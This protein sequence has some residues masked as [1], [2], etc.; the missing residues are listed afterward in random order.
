[1]TYEAGHEFP[2]IEV[3]SNGRLYIYDDNSSS[4]PLHTGWV[5]FS[6]EGSDTRTFNRLYTESWGCVISLPSLPF[7]ARFA[8]RNQK[9]QP[10]GSCLVLKDFMVQRD[11]FLDFETH[12]ILAEVRVDF[13]D[14]TYA[15]KAEYES[16]PREGSVAIVPFE[17][18]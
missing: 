15:V 11:V 5:A 3:L 9:M 1:M 4:R 16:D 17:L 13:H 7:K 6:F 10:E 8:D 18:V 2:R 14:S 12:S